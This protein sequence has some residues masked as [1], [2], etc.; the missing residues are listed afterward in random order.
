MML[1]KIYY[2]HR[3]NDIP[4][5]IGKFNKKSRLS[6]HKKKFGKDIQLVIID[7][8]AIIEWKFWE[9]FYISLYKSWGFK[10][11]NKNNGGGGPTYMSEDV[12]I[13]M[14]NKIKN[15]KERGIKIG[16]SNRGR[17]SPMKGKSQTKEWKKNMSILI[18]NNLD[19]G[20]K[21]SNSLNSL[22]PL[23]KQH[24]YNLISIS[25]SKPIFQY[26]LQ[27]N[28]IKEWK[29]SKEASKALNIYDSNIN[30][31]LKGKY[32]YSGGYKWKYKL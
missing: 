23:E 7:E 5:Y 9:K 2:L 14:S 30:C 31:C 4:F 32:K 10:L 3:G 21:I 27:D 6:S 24:K 1:T 8:I 29:S 25:N 20:N 12:K 11:E 28:F 16:N 13:L 19:R 22:S 17:I 18:S 26:D 15:N